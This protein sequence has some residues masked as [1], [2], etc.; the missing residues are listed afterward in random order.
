MSLP[1]SMAEACE[2]AQGCGG[3]MVSARSPCHTRVRLAWEA[4]EVSC[5]SWWTITMVRTFLS[6][7][8]QTGLPEETD[9]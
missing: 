1:E 6:A 7:D 5:S 8:A 9:K 4:Y 3:C 2:W